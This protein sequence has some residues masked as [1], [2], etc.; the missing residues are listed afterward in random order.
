MP[1]VE[2]LILVIAE[3][4]VAFRVRD[5]VPEVPVPPSV[6]VPI[7]GACGTV[8]GVTAL[9]AEDAEEV[10]LAFVAVTVYVRAVPTA[11]EIEMG[12]V[13]PVAVPP[14]DDVIVYEVIVEPPVAL[15]VKGTETVA[16]AP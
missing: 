3:P 16:L 8:V 14:L 5:R 4:P 15:A 6:K 11:S 12:L 1:S 2:Y 7:V 13:A 9:E 10:P